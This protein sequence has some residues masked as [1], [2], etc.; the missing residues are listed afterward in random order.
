MTLTELR[1]IV[2]DLQ[3]K[4]DRVCAAAHQVDSLLAEVDGLINGQYADTF[5]VDAL[6]ALQSPRYVALLTELEEATDVLGTDNLT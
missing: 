6:V 2:A 4:V 1:N 3:P 5:N